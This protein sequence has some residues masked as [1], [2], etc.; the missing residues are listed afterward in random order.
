MVNKAY[1]LFVSIFKDPRQ[2]GFKQKS[3]SISSLIKKMTNEEEWEYYE[4]IQ[5][6][7]RTQ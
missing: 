2:E 7:M 4:R 6:F 5:D 3:T 1:E